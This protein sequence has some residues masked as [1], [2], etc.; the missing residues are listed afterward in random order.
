MDRVDSETRS[1]IMSRIKSQNTKP[2]HKV[3]E[4]LSLMFSSETVV[5]HPKEMLGTPDFFV[6]KCGLVVFVDGCFFHGCRKHCRLPE[7][8]GEYWRS[9]ISRNKAR[10]RQVNKRLREAGYLVVR[11]WEH[12]TKGSMSLAKS[13]IKKALRRAANK[14]T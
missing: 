6:P 11:I 12:E 4:L 8:N 14:P 2:E 5:C 13:K 3:N 7:N 1:K 10:D 9:K